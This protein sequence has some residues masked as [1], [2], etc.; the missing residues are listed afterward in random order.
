M[1]SYENSTNTESKCI[2]STPGQRLCLAEDKYI[3]GVGTYTR[4]GYIMSCL[5]GIV[6]ITAQPD[7]RILVEVRSGKEQ[8]VV[9]SAG[10]IVTARITQVNPRW[11]RCAI[12]CVKEMVLAEPFRG[13]L[14]K[15]DVRATEKDRVEMYKCFRPNDIILARVLSLGDAHSYVLSTAENE[16]GVVIAYSEEGTPMVPVGWQEMQCPKT[17]VKEMRKVAK[18]SPEIISNENNKEAAN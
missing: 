15:E 11:A 4:Q 3:G 14:R 6:K 9:P 5:A 2:I 7:K 13:Q 1:T 18:V 16:L 12:L 17:Y 8:T 10:D